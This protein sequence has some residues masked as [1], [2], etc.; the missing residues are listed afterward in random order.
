MATT[1]QLID[2]ALRSIGVLASGEEAKPDEVQDA[3]LY[4]TAL[5]ESWANDGLLVYARTHETFSLSALGGGRTFTIGTGGDF[6]TARPVYIE[7]LRLRDSGGLETPITQYSL[8]Q[9]ANIPIKDSVRN[10]PEGFY[11]EPSFP[12][13]TIYF[14]SI[15]DTGDTVYLVSMKQLSDLP[16]L[17]TDT[18]YPPG[19][20]R[21]IRLGLA[22]EM[23]P[24][25]G[26]PVTPEMG[27]MYRDALYKLKRTNSISRV[28]ALRVDN[29][30]T[31]KRGYDVTSG[32][33]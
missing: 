25:Y 28:P 26:K 17:G 31:R 18:T 14:S 27:A 20:D 1:K 10:Y 19:Y 12:L 8:D 13:G 9:Y 22:I 24:E 33:E 7:N 5:L 15:P 2:K 32:P 21:A 29:G 23:A 11:Y 30:L 16:A 6:N 4:A 3:L